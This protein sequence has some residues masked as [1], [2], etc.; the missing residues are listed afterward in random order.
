MRRREALRHLASLVEQ[1]DDLV[2]Y[3]LAAFAQV[4]EDSSV[5]AQARELLLTLREQAAGKRNT[6]PWINLFQ[7]LE[8]TRDE[9]GE[10]PVQIVLQSEALMRLADESTAA[11][12]V[13]LTPSLVDPPRILRLD[14]MTD[15]ALDRPPPEPVPLVGDDEMLLRSRPVEVPVPEAALVI[16]GD[17]I[18]V[19]FRLTG[20]TILKKR[21]DMPGRWTFPSSYRIGDPLNPEEIESAWPGARGEPVGARSFH[22]RDEEKDNIDR[23]L[24]GRDR[25]H[26]LMVFGQR[27]IGKTSLLKEVVRAY[28]P[29]P[30]GVCGVFIDVNSLEVPPEQGAMPRKFFDFIVSKLNTAEDVNEPLRQALYRH[31]GR[32]VDIETLARGLRPDI[33]LEDALEELVKRLE[34]A[35]GGLIKRLA[36]FLDEFDLFVEPLLA[37]RRDEVV[38]LHGSLRQI[39]QRSQRL[40]LVMAGSGLQRLFT[41][42]YLHPFYGSV[43]E[44]PL[45]PF[46]WGTERDR[47]AAEDTFLP[48]HLRPRLCSGG[49][50]TKVARRASDLSGGHPYFL[51]MLGYAVARAWRGHPLTPEMLNRIADLMIQNKIDTGTIDV[52]RRKFYMFIF[53]SLKRLS[54]RQRALAHLMLASMARLTSTQQQHWKRWR[55]TMEEFIEDPEVRRL[56]TEGERLAA[57]QYLEKERVVELDSGRS[58]VRIRIP[59]TASAIREDARE[60]H[61]DAVRQLKVLAGE[62]Q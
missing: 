56:T 49:Q 14:F 24:Q 5:R 35:S 60:I 11:V 13:L 3:C 57:L 51:S 10:P 26:S 19:S 61:D 4:E 37:G 8:A 53:E 54:P 30:G 45:R 21:I 40:S 50:F 6:R 38:R 15:P 18:D 62:G 41:E 59:L 23:Y 31:A 46:D 7:H 16:A 22:G 25:M 44:L 12:Q 55:L 17:L 58:G 1:V 9:G 48:A 47:T 33:A 52:N 27:R 43:D 42:D 20:E 36:L 34:E 32:R 29:T 28:P 2:R 39:I